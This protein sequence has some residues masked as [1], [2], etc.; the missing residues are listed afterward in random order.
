MNEKKKINVAFCLN[1]ALFVAVLFS[2][3]WMMSGIKLAKHSS[4]SAARLA[5]LKYYT[6][7]SNILMGI[8]ALLMLICDLRVLRG[9]VQGIPVFAKVIK[10]MGTVGVTL[11][12]LVTIFFL[13]PTAQYNWLS[14]FTDSNFFM[15]LL[16]PVLA[17]VV[18]LGFERTKDISFKHTFTGMT[19]MP[20]YGVFYITNAVIHSEN[21]MVPAV[22]DWYGFLVA[23]VWSA[24]IV[25][26]LV[27]VITYIISLVLWKL[28]R[29]KQ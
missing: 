15:H 19:T 6:V 5:S 21:G 8:A 7:D 26:P 3:A 13:A 2:V 22:H 16:N 23:G 12:M 28:N 17:L 10:L 27:T 14:L 11:T 29:L 18:F 1:T 4:L 9:K 25:L 20:I 24:V